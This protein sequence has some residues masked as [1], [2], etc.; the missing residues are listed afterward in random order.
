ME[1]FIQITNLSRENIKELNLESIERIEK[2]AIKL[3]PTKVKESFRIL[4]TEIKIPSRLSTE[5]DS[6]SS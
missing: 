2:L 5:T 6:L 1:K 3:S 4:L